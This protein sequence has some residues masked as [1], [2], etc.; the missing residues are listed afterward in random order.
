VLAWWPAS[1]RLTC[2]TRDEVCD[3]FDA[4]LLVLRFVNGL[5]GYDACVGGD[6]VYAVAP[7]RRERDVG[8]RTRRSCREDLPVSTI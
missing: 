2:P 7:A 3:G 1:L 6:A 8:M 5:G 4:W